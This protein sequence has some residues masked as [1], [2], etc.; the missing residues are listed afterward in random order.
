MQQTSRPLLSKLC[1]R[2]Q[3]LV[4]DPHF[5]EVRGGV[6]PWLMAHWNACV[7][8]L[9][10]VIELLFTALRNA[11]IAIAVLATAIPYVCPSVTRRYCVKTVR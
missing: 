2:L 11:H 3:I 9:L 4:F 6:E 7:E 5:E 1:E 8:L 10:S